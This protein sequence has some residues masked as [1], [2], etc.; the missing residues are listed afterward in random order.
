MKKKQNSDL[1]NKGK[2]ELI[3]EASNCEQE[4]KE[5]KYELESNDIEC[6][7]ERFKQEVKVKEEKIKEYEALMDEHKDRYLRLQADFDNYRKRVAKERED[8][9][10]NALEDIM[11]QLL[12][13]VDNLERA[14]D[15]FENGDLDKKYVDGLNMIYKDFMGTL[16]KNGLAEVEALGSEFD[17]NKH[18]AVMQ[19]D[20]EEED[21]NV[22]KDVFQKGYMLKAK[23]IRP[24]MVKVAT[25]S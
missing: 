18:H 8:I 11:I 16:S 9:F 10:S 4:N 2:D 15:S 3:E 7:L 5:T 1:K 19:V 6:E 20:A 23:V 25:K 14:L 24:A 17:P 12:P 13:I 22:I 21:E